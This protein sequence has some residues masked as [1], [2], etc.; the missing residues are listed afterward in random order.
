MKK[1]ETYWFEYHNNGEYEVRSDNN[2]GQKFEM[3]THQLLGNFY[4]IKCET[5][6]CAAM[7]YAHWLG[8]L[9]FHHGYIEDIS[10]EIL[11]Q[12]NNSLDL[13]KDAVEKAYK[14]D[15]STMTSY[16]SV[17]KLEE[18]ISKQ[19]KKEISLENK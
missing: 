13:F 8:E 3:T 17:D 1:G 18:I 12:M 14:M 10:G 2:L 16:I 11:E 6:I 7:D 4:P 5:D 9:G 19:V 15:Y